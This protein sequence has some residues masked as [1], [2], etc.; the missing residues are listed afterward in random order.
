MDFPTKWHFRLISYCGDKDGLRP[1][2]FFQ[3][4]P[5]SYKTYSIPE[6]NLFFLTFAQILN[7]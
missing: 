3:P 6:G 4:L 7:L 2:L 1:F 5:F